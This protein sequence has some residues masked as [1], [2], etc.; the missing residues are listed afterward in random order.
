[1]TN[2]TIFFKELRIFLCSF[3]K[4][5]CIGHCTGWLFFLSV[6]LGCAVIVV[7]RLSVPEV[8]IVQDRARLGDDQAPFWAMGSERRRKLLF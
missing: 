8:L 3:Y 4:S 2:T 6:V 5:D 7:G 1:M